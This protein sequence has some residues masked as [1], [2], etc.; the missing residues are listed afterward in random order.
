VAWVAGVAARYQI[1]TCRFW[2]PEKWK[3]GKWKGE[4]KAGQEEDDRIDISI[5]MQCS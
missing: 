5:A 2:L 4:E 1:L 3:G